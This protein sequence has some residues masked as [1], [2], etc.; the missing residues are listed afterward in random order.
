VAE[1]VKRKR[2]GENS[3]PRSLYR[4]IQAFWVSLISTKFP[5]SESV[6]IQN[7]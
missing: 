1:V 2:G 4:L 7:C 3:S 6:Q 5:P